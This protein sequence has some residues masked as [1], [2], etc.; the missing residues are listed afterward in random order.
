M[1]AVGVRLYLSGP[2]TGIPGLNRPSFAAVEHFLTEAGYQVTNPAHN[3]VPDEAPRAE[4]LRADLRVL[5]DCDG[6]ATLP[7]YT[8]SRGAR[9]EVRVAAGLDMPVKPW[10]RWLP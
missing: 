7:G 8:R 4:H 2:M 10:Q 9:L 5:L 1:G 3:D 6:V